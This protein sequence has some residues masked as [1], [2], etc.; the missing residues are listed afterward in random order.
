MALG[1]TEI[2]M[3]EGGRWL[4]EGP[5]TDVAHGNLDSLQIDSTFP[6]GCQNQA[7]QTEGCFTRTC[8]YAFVIFNMDCKAVRGWLAGEG[9]TEFGA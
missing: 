8:T 1:E 3:G 2:Q 7:F 4:E 5:W 6:L 9:N